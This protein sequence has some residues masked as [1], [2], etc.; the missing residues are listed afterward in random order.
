MCAFLSNTIAVLV[1]AQ[2][3]LS[4]GVGV[5]LFATSGPRKSFDQELR[6]MHEDGLKTY[7]R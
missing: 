3:M 4:L 7:R 2:F 6:D 5:W 1:V